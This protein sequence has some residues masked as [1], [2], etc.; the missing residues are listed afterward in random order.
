MDE[1][2]ASGE[3]LDSKEER[4]FFRATIDEIDS[5]G[6]SLSINGG[7]EK[8]QKKY[9]YLETGAILQPGDSVLVVK[10]TGTYVVLGRIGTGMNMKDVIPAND[11]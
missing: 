2:I 4:L 1:L 3:L 10:M 7:L 5:E 11:Y 6:I 9:K 8:L